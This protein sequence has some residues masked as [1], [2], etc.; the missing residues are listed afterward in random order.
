M[1]ALATA[2]KLEANKL[3]REISRGGNVTQ[4]TKNLLGYQAIGA[5]ILT[6]HKR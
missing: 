5:H 2:I 6:T 4:V 1:R 3:D